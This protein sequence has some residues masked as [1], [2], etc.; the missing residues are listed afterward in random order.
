MGLIV[1]TG[2]AGTGKT[3]L[4]GRLGDYLTEES[5]EFALLLDSRLSAD[6]FYEFLAYDLALPC[7]RKSNVA[8]LNALRELLLEQA[9]KGS[10]AAL[11]I[12]DA[13]HLEW[14]V[15]EE[16]RMLDNLQ[17]RTGR[18][19]QTVLCGSPELEQ[20]LESDEFCQ[21]G[22][23]VAVRFHLQPPSE[24]ETGQ[25]IQR[26]LTDCG[27]PDQTVFTPEIL[28]AIHARSGGLLRV[29]RA[30]CDRLLE[31][32]FARGSRVATMEMLDAVWSDMQSAAG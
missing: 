12:D 24:E 3:T 14:E 6:E 21:L 18:L 20:R 7:T 29:T 13:H 10:T 2:E 19:L 5:M 22:E 17:H 23:R 1:L 4:L 26:E 28:S 16:I 32:C 25:W 30:I 15:L 27:M 8:V 9:G 11:L 31:T